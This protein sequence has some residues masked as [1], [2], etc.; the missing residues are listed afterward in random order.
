MNKFF[1]VF[2]AASLLGCVGHYQQPALNE[3]HATLEA[4]WGDNN[5]IDGGFQGYWAYY[6]AHCQ[7]TS[8]TGVLG[9]VSQSDPDKNR[10]LIQPDRRIFLSGLSSGIKQRNSIAPPIIHRACLSISSFVPRAGVTYQITHLA[11]ESGCTLDVID[12]QTGKA[13]STLIVEPI[14]K[15]C[16]L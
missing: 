1:I 15:E 3:P 5:I 8:Q 16:G 14:S 6:D 10:F 12:V 13:P 4:K 7:D 2:C 9:S 11:P